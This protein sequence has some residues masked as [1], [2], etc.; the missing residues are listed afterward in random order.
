MARPNWDEYF[1]DVVDAIAKRSNC[2]RGK[3]AAVI[4]K[5]RR[6]VSTGY[7]GAPRG[8]PSCDEV[9]HELI[10][11]DKWELYNDKFMVPGSKITSIH[12]IRTVH[13]E[14]NAIYNAAYH[15]VAL[16][17]SIMYCTMVPCRVCAMGIIQVG[18]N[19]IIAK[20]GYHTGEDAIKMFQKARIELIVWNDKFL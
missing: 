18:I 3:P 11:M 13:A 12:C 9:G 5:D 2:D 16:K 15:G 4:V 17:D 19:K 8:F 1:M 10:Q 14:L 20:N 7:A 6:I